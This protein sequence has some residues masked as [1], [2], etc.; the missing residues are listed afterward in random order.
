MQFAFLSFLRQYALFVKL[1]ALV[2]LKGVD[3]GSCLPDVTS[4]KAR[5]NSY[6]LGYMLYSKE[7]LV[8]P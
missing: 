6:S 2:Y 8:S 4:I 1:H 7:V 3:P 5:Y